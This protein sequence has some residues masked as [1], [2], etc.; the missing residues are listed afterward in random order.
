VISKPFTPSLD[1][2]S[3]CI[4]Y[5]VSSF[6]LGDN[7]GKQTASFL[8]I[9]DETKQLSSRSR[10]LRTRGKAAM[11]AVEEGRGTSKQKR[12][13][14]EGEGGRKRLKQAWP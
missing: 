6:K 13:V 11:G 1:S 14:G 7:T 4:E 8:F 9:F 3:A 12:R 5:V 2:S 10:R